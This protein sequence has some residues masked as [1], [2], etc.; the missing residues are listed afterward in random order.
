M[1]LL[2]H[3]LADSKMARAS[4]G[5]NSWRLLIHQDKCHFLRDVPKPLDFPSGLL[6]GREFPG[7]EE[8]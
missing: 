5:K 4:L 8:R 1:E 7:T 3:V 2:L 6:D